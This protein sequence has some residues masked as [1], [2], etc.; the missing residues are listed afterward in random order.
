MKKLLTVCLLVY[1]SHALAQIKSTEVDSLIKN[2]TF[3]FIVSDVKKRPGLN[4]I[5]GSSNNYAAA[6]N[7]NPSVMTPLQSQKITSIPIGGNGSYVQT[8]YYR[9]SQLDG[10]YFTSY[11]LYK[12][13][14]N[15]SS[16]DTYAIYLIQGREQLT[17]NS[18]QNPS[19]VAKIKS[20]DFYAIQSADYELKSAKKNN[21]KWLLTYH[22]KNGD[23][24]QAFYLNI[25]PDGSAILTQQATR[26]STTVLQGFITPSSSTNI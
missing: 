20:S 1:A 7:I 25:N 16:K 26:E 23:Q 15:L 12:K 3:T 24:A 19:T 11:Q 22:L 6:Y 5:S 17:L 4:G 21:G 8:E 14:K 9:L 10:S 13:D 2:K 18:L